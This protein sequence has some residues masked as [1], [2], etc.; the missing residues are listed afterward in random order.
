[1]AHIK[2]YPSLLAANLGKLN[3][4]VKEVEPFAD[5]LHI[6]VM[7]GH[8]VPNIAM[9]PSLVSYIKT[10]L[11]LDIHLMVEHPRQFVAAYAKIGA[12]R[13]TFH[14][15]AKDDPKETIADMRKHGCKAAIALNPATPLEKI[16]PFIDT[17]DMVLG[18]SVVPGFAGQ[19][20]MPDVL[21]KVRELRRLRPLL[22]IQ[23]DGGINKSNIARAV[24]AGANVIVAATAIF[25]H[26][27]RG[28]AIKELREAIEKVK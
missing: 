20:F 13:M 25:R 11:P 26:A 22:D 8:F 17:V 14:I 2:I 6:D 10:A 24:E 15:E 16:L 21:E 28:E 27:D 4:E 1:M 3:D 12:S 19:Q 23:I 5:A 9:G 18:M 7:D